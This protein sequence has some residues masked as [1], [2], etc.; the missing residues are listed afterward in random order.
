MK[1]LLTFNRYNSAHLKHLRNLII[2]LLGSYSHGHTS[3]KDR[4]F[5]LILPYPRNFQFCYIL[6]HI[7]SLTTPFLL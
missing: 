2:V 4:L 1:I 5:D 6:S 3:H 7:L